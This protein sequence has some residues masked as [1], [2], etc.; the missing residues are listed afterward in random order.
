MTGRW[1]CT[2]YLRDAAVRC[3]R[4]RPPSLRRAAISP[5]DFSSYAYRLEAGAIGME[6]ALL[7]SQLTRRFA[8]SWQCANARR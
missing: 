5:L 6:Q 8:R 2:E 7:P 3:A 4:P 1:V